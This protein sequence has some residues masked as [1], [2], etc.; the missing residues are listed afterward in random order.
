MWKKPWILVASIVMLGLVVRAYLLFFSPLPLYWDEVAMLIDARSVI[1]T[2][3]DLHGGNWL[4]PLYPS[5][6]DFKLPVYIL[7]TAMTMLLVGTQDWVVRVP[8]LLAGVGTIIV[9]AA[10]GKEIADKVYKKANYVSFAMVATGLI[11]AF[12]PWSLHFSRVG[13]EAHLAQ[14]LVSCSIWLLLRNDG[15]Y[16]KTVLAALLGVLATYTYFSV[17]FVWPVVAATAFVLFE[18]PDKLRSVGLR[19]SFRAIAPLVMMLT[20]YA[21]LLIPLYRSEYYEQS[22]QLRYSTSSVLNSTDYALQSNE[23]RE[24]AGNHWYTR[25]LFHRN[26]L[27]IRAFGT[28]VSQNISANFLFISGDNNLR[29]GTAQ[30]GLFVT[31]LLLVFAVGWFYLVKKHPK[32]GILLVTWWLAAVVPAS[33]PHEVPHALRSLNALVPLVVVMGFGYTELL[34]LAVESRFRIVATTG[35]ALYTGVI[36]FV[37]AEF[38]T[39]YS[40]LY[41]KT[42]YTAWQGGYR[43]QIAEYQV[44][45]KKHP[46][47]RFFLWQWAYGDLTSEHIQSLPKEQFRPR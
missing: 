15:L 31:P 40:V 7:T 18:F 32:A 29:H 8:S 14:F 34:R 24:Q 19:R 9:A 12:S 35:M 16:K 22:S 30:H 10:V 41:P 21:V 25:F 13:F 42:A 36:L 6:G 43:E 37:S 2:G 3:R 4:Q 17:R 45:E 20:L 5:Y 26:I 47:D 28:N 1:E 11:M 27:L 23:L 46:D 39:Y 38:L 33:V 44:S